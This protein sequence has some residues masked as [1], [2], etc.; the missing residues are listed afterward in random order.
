[1]LLRL[2]WLLSRK[3]LLAAVAIDSGLFSLLYTAAFLF[4]FGRWPGLSLPVAGMVTFWLLSSYVIGRYHVTPSGRVALA[5]KHA[6]RTG[7]A[8]L[9]GLGVY[10]T[11][12]WLSAVT[13]A[14]KDSRGFLVPLLL[15][16]ALLSNVAQAY[17]ARIV[18]IRHQ[19][20]QCWLFLGDSQVQLRLEQHLVWRRL[21]AHLESIDDQQFTSLKGGGYAGVLCADFNG[22]PAAQLQLLLQLQ[23]SGLPVLSLMGWCERVLQ[24]FPPELLTDA[25]LLRGEFLLTG[26]TMQLRLKRLGD[27]LV[28]GGLLLLTAPIL[29][30]AALLIHLQDG[31]PVLY[32]Q[33]RSGL[34]SKSY[35]IWKLRTMRVDAER[36]GAQWVANGDARITPLGRLLR[37]TRLDELPQLWAVLQSEMSLIG[38]RPERP[39]FEQELERQIPHYRLRHR[40]RPGL[41]GWAQV[42]YPYGASVEDASNKLS[43]DLY[44]LRNFSFWLDLLI[45]F[46]TIRLVFNAQGAVPTTQSG[47][48]P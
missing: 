24:R 22:V 28:S 31:G 39:E 4:R 18:L 43:Y 12:F 14:A 20:S 10:L 37:L 2:P 17:L 6:L 45:L 8:L 9:L 11:Y 33:L 13:L 38:P 29:L 32:S 19:Q 46:K 15:A 16:F 1:M 27:L 30:L 42:N 44:Y 34:D 21:S 41:S 48:A 25:D 35:R 47:T 23:N 36:H 40:M 7:V 26:S 3:R 5:L